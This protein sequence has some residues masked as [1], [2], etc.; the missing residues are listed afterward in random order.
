MKKRE[1]EE[2]K[3]GCRSVLDIHFRPSRDDND[4][5]TKKKRNSSY[6][7]QFSSVVI[8]KKAKKA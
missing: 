1:K 4:T 8:G 6:L 7:S 3:K 2:G 5:K